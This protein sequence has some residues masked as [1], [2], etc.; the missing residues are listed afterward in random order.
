MLTSSATEPEAVAGTAHDMRVAE[1]KVADAPATVP[2]KQEAVAK[3]LVPVTLMTEPPALGASAG[4][5]EVTV[6][7]AVRRERETVSIKTIYTVDQHKRDA[8][9]DKAAMKAVPQQNKQH[10]QTTQYRHK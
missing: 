1:V 8:G 6:A 4:A 10:K 5:K 3:K 7:S 9:T 2:K